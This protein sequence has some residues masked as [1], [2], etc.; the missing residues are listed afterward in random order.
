[1]DY[2]ALPY[3]RTWWRW[4]FFRWTLRKLVCYTNTHLYE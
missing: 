2:L 4:M 3:T 1:L